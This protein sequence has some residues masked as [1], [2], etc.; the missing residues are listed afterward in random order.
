VFLSPLRP[1]HPV[2]QTPLLTRETENPE[3][4]NAVCNPNP[5]RCARFPASRSSN[6]ESSAKSFLDSGIWVEVGAAEQSRRAVN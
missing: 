6:Q 5:E 2:N 4:E 3:E 1:E